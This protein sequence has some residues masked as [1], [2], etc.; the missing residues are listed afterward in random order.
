MANLFRYHWSTEADHG[1]PPACPKSI[2]YI[3]GVRLRLFVHSIILSRTNFSS[4]LHFRLFF[5]VPSPFTSPHFQFQNIVPRH[6]HF[7]FHVRLRTVPPTHPTAIMPRGPP[8]PTLADF[9]V[10][11]FKTIYVSPEFKTAF[12]QVLK[13]RPHELFEWIIASDHNSAKDL[14]DVLQKKFDNRSSKEFYSS[15]HQGSSDL[16][17][18]FGTAQV[19]QYHQLALAIAVLME[20]DSRIGELFDDMVYKRCVFPVTWLLASRYLPS[21]V[22]RIKGKTKQESFSTAPPCALEAI[23]YFHALQYAILHGGMEFATSHKRISANRIGFAVQLVINAWRKLADACTVEPALTV[24]SMLLPYMIF[25]PD[26]F[27]FS[28]L[29]SHADGFAPKTQHHTLLQQGEPTL[30]RE[31]TDM[32]A[33]TRSSEQ[34]RALRFSAVLF[35]DTLHQLLKDETLYV[36]VGDKPWKKAEELCCSDDMLPPIFESFPQELADALGLELA[37]DNSKDSPPALS[38]TNDPI[39]DDEDVESPDPSFS[40]IN[41]EIPPKKRARLSLEFQGLKAPPDGFGKYSVFPEHILAS[42]APSVANWETIISLRD[43][44]LD[45][46]NESCVSVVKNTGQSNLQLADTIASAVLIRGSKIAGSDQSKGAYCLRD[47]AKGDQI[48]YVYGTLIYQDVTS[49]PSLWFDKFF[50]TKVRKEIAYRAILLGFI[51]EKECAE[52]TPVY[53]VP[54]PWTVAAAIQRMKGEGNVDIEIMRDSSCVLVCAGRDL[55]AGEELVF[56]F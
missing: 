26:T 30:E 28:A 18:E 38:A 1:A 39:L 34:D 53:V 10:S 15:A 29:A 5:L 8:K 25:N 33:S 50:P 20:D 27:Q 21:V 49:L 6:L 56:G 48:C 37:I 13:K 11:H 19:L 14:V 35:L 47:I 24:T 31:L 2:R 55:R 46:W 51:D 17:R 45:S 22:Y 44:P 41:A 16:L 40:E 9:Y 4:R 32:E 52:S 23:F 36:S 43:I 3:P 42:I 12:P 7:H 54:F